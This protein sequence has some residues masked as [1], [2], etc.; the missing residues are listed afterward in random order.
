[1]LPGQGKNWEEKPRGDGGGSRGLGNL[2]SATSILRFWVGHHI[3]PWL[4]D[5]RSDMLINSSP[6]SLLE[7][8]DLRLKPASYVDVSKR[9]P[10]THRHATH[11]NVTKTGNKKDTCAVPCSPATAPFYGSPAPSLRC[12]G[13]SSPL[14]DTGRHSRNLLKDVSFLQFS[15]SLNFWPQV[16][17]L[18]SRTEG[19]C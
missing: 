19:T 5:Q 4:P 12:T 14:P 1:M 9:R 16:F 7:L 2:A 13:W 8:W 17:R 3:S 18:G 11:T 6:R 15:L 10:H